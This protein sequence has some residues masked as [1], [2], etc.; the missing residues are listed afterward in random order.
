MSYTRNWRRS[1]AKTFRTRNHA[2]RLTLLPAE[3][4]PGVSSERLRF[5]RAGW[6]MRRGIQLFCVS[7]GLVY[8]IGFTAATTGFKQQ[9]AVADYDR[10]HLV[11]TAQLLLVTGIFVP[12]LLLVQEREKSSAA[13]EVTISGEPQSLRNLVIESSDG[14]LYIET[15]ENQHVDNIAISLNVKELKELFSRGYSL[16]E[17]DGLSAQSLTLE[18]HGGGHIDIRHLEATDLTV[19]GEGAS[20]FSVSGAV[21]N[22]YVDLHGVGVY[23]AQGLASQTSQVNVRGSSQV[24]LWVADMLD[25]SVFGNASIIYSG[26]PWVQQRMLGTGVIY[27]VGQ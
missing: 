7:L 15:G 21:K 18:S 3:G 13:S 16:V 4:M 27:R 26:R 23:E 12:G 20:K 25:V 6:S 14:V 9:L 17:A 22:Q 1:K 19:V 11:G 24:A 2:A 5:D 8:T 10:I